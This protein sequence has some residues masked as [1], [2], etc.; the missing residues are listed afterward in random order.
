M[1]HS[2]V[3]NLFTVIYPLL[4]ASCSRILSNMIYCHCMIE[5]MHTKVNVRMFAR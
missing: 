4:T 1:L 3:R 5:K 2:L